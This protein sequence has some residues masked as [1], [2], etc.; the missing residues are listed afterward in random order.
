MV[1]NPQLVYFV[2]QKKMSANY[3]RPPPPPFCALLPWHA[4]AVFLLLQHH[5]FPKTTPSKYP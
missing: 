5:P 1:A 4:T 2:F 3:K